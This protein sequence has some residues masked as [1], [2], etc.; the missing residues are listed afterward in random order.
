MHDQ[1]HESGAMKPD[2]IQSDR[3]SQEQTSKATQDARQQSAAAGNDAPHGA[4]A[5]VGTRPDAHPNH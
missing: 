5:T 1:D 4:S 2:G 3:H